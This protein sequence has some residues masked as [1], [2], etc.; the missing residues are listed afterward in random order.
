MLFGIYS[1]Q[2]KV[3]R[4]SNVFIWA[5]KETLFSDFSS[6]ALMVGFIFIVSFSFSSWIFVIEKILFVC[7]YSVTNNSPS[8]GFHSLVFPQ[9]SKP[10][11][12][13]RIYWRGL[14]CLS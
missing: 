6:T 12:N 14:I 5:S 7:L 4:A 2:V 13:L 8:S 9:I 10:R 1:T 3:I 11:V